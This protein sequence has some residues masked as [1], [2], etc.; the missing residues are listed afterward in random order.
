MVG[1]I[2]GKLV[3]QEEHYSGSL[4]VLVDFDGFSARYDWL[5]WV[6]N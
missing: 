4:K 3:C 2:G 5:Q 6:L 1:D